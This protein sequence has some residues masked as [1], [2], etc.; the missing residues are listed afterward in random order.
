MAKFIEVTDANSVKKL[1]NVDYIFEIE[2]EDKTGHAV[3]KLEVSGFN[4]YAFQYV[5]TDMDY[6][7]VRHII[8]DSIQ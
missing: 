1:L 2:K 6:W 8:D 4:G 3:I 7:D 5:E